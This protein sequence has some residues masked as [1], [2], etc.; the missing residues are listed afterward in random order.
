[1][2]FGHFVRIADFI[3]K[4]AMSENT[5]RSSARGRRGGWLRS[6]GELPL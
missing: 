2:V 6:S 4:V 5:G 1:M 3:R